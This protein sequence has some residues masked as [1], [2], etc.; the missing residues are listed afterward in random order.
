MAR[1]PLPKH[2]YC[3]PQLV[4]N[5]NFHLYMD[6]CRY[7]LAFLLV[8]GQSV[9]V[10]GSDDTEFVVEESHVVAAAAVVAH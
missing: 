5:D 3:W 9:R 2:P 8:V 4:Y 7:K 6:P 1:L 10:V